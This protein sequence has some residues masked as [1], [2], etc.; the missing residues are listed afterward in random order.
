MS[1]SLKS[2]PFCGSEKIICNEDC[3][4]IAANYY[5]ECANCGAQTA[6]YDEQELAVENWNERANISYKQEKAGDLFKLCKELL[7]ECEAIIKFFG[8][9][10]GNLF[11]KVMHAR[12][13]INNILLHE[14]S[15]QAEAQ[16]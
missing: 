11:R 14:H 4:E 13:I 7:E 1:Q 5:I 8:I 2:C 6:L 9:D 10:D 12:M 15:K 16:S 3:P